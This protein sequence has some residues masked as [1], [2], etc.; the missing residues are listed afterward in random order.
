MKKLY[1]GYGIY[2][3]II[4]IYFLYFY[5]LETFGP[6]RI[7]AYSHAFYFALLPFEWIFLI[8]IICHKKLWTKIEEDLNRGLSWWKE[9]KW[10]IIL[11]LF[12]LLLRLPF[13]VVYFE[14]VKYYGLSHETLAN[15]FYK[16]SLDAFAF[17]IGAIFLVRL[18]RFA[19]ARFPKKWWLFSWIT[20][21]PFALFLVYIQPVWIDPLYEEFTPIEEGA[22][23]E[24]IEDVVE[25]AGIS[26]AELL[27]VEKSDE[28]NRYNAYVTGIGDHARIVLWD[29]TL[30]HLSI[31]GI[32]FILNH[33]IAHYIEGH[34]YW[35]VFGYLLLSLSILF[36]LA[37]VYSL[38]NRNIGNVNQRHPKTIPILILMT[39]ILL[40][41][42]QPG[43]LYVSRHMEWRADEYAVEHTDNLEPAIETYEKL[44]IESQSDLYP[45]WWVKWLRNSH[46][47][48]GER[49]DFIE[50]SANTKSEGEIS[51][52][53]K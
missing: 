23:R 33:E 18:L 43:S 9:G 47:P 38:Y 49:L 2:A 20:I 30:N 3:V 26:N 50:R 29:T 4:S 24:A 41:I 27:Q 42:L 14:L 35:G 40:F 11:G 52:T 1:W 15:W 45:L 39:S 31:D 21:L 51:G 37:N 7:A 36:V 25:D 46:P 48:M 6:S 8:S 34:F 5:P 28:T 17:L 12:Y 19:L 13:Q 10:T 44:A 32:T 22:T 53:N 16:W